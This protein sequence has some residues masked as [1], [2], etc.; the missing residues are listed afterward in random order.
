MEE[1]YDSTLIGIL[2]NEGKIEKFL[3]VIFGFLYRRT[4]FYRHMK[5][6]EDKL[7][8]PPGISQKMIMTVFQQYDSLARQDDM[9][10]EAKKEETEKLKQQKEQASGGDIPV[11]KKSK[12]DTTE[13]VGSKTNDSHKSIQQTCNTSDQLSDKNNSVKSNNKSDVNSKN[14]EVS[15]SKE[16]TN[17]TENLSK[18]DTEDEEKRQQ[19]KFQEN[20]ESYNGAVRDNYSWSQSITDLDVRVKVPDYIRKGRDA[21]VDIGKKHLK[22]SYK[23]DTGQWKMI[24]DGDL[25]WEVQK[26]ECMW[27]LN[28]GDNIHINFE[29]KDE[30]WWEAVLVDE[31]KINVRKIDASRPMTDLDD[32]AQAKIEEMMYN[33]R[34][35][36]MGLPTS[37]EQKM[38]DMLKNAWDAEGSPFKGQPFDPSKFSMDSSGVLQMKPPS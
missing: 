17:K 38:Q 27:T 3:N 7:G 30:R 1:K 35:K 32:E 8:F 26:D 37:E 2:Q 6:K 12:S 20:P 18:D 16:D 4:D 11:E 13:T 28:P 24:I 14:T 15:V 21:K 29:K 25:T 10:R 23:D 22:V 34:R 9:K 33:D 31:P 36:K 19:R 5:S